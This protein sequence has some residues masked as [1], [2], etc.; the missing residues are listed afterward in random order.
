MD[1]AVRTEGLTKRYGDVLALD[2]LDFQVEQGEI[3]GYLGPNGAGKTTT[4]RL[5]LDVIRPNEGSA[6]VLGRD[7]RSASIEVRRRV[8]YLPGDFIVD[9][10]QTSR[11]FLTYIGNLRGGVA[12]SR[13]E[14]LAERLELQLSTPIRQLSK[15]NRQKVGLIQAFMHEPELLILDEPTGGLDPLMQH[16]FQEMASEVKAEGRTIFMSSHVLSEVQRVADRVGIIR[17]GRL[18]TIEKI[19]TLRERSVRR[20][21]IVFG[22]PVEAGSFETIDEVKD[23][24]VNGHVLRCLLAGSPDALIKA[25]ARHQVVSLLAE[26][27]DLEE[28]FFDYYRG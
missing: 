3:F 4:I 16:T 5:L 9:G 6:E 28:V 10:R 19:E 21:E 27:P 7:T 12:R 15:G 18:V 25:A 20:V 17:D 22:E 26:E 14:T 2:K 24:V 13:I 23:V 1:S 11:E 8:G